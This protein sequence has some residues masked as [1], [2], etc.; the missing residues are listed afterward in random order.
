M[1]G[2]F[3][4]TTNYGLCKSLWPVMCIGEH[5]C[6]VYNFVLCSIISQLFAPIGSTQIIIKSIHD[7]IHYDKQSIHNSP[8]HPL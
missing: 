4:N 2:Y 7:L 8:G 3:N 1:T 6:E 5:T